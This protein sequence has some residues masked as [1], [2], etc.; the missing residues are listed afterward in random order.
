MVSFPSWFVCC[1]RLHLKLLQIL[2]EISPAIPSIQQNRS[3]GSRDHMEINYSREARF[4]CICVSL[5]RIRRQ[6]SKLI[7][8]HWLSLHQTRSALPCVVRNKAART[9]TLPTHSHL[10][11]CTLAFSFHLIHCIV[12]RFWSQRCADLTVQTEYTKDP[13]PC[14]HL[15]LYFKHVATTFTVFSL[16]DNE[17]KQPFK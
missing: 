13:Y 5:S 11:L 6:W 12:V 7:M 4:F 14:C 10:L 8:W 2:K 16:T 17:C 9:R 15:H 3:F 1:T